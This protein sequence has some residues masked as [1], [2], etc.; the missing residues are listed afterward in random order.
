MTPFQF[1][2]KAVAVDGFKKLAPLLLSM[3]AFLNVAVAVVIVV[4]DVAD[5]DGDSDDDC[6]LGRFYLGAV[7]RTRLKSLKYN[8]Y[9]Q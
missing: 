1:S 2:P 6:I 8:L 7:E 4:V 5:D 9:L 3:F